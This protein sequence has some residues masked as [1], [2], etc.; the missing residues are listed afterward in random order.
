MSRTHQSSA[1]S[2]PPGGDPSS[3]LG[4]STFARSS[5]EGSHANEFCAN[6]KGTNTQKAVEEEARA[7]SA[8]ESPLAKGR[9][10]LSKED[11]KVVALV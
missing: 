5:Q 10:E 7:H 6:P 11:E 4:Q 2:L 9:D 8:D 3:L 1:Q